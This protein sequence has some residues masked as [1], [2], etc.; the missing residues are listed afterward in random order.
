MDISKHVV[1]DKYIQLYLSIK[2]NFLTQN[3]K[4]NTPGK[5]SGDLAST[6]ESVM[7]SL[8]ELIQFTKPLRACFLINK[9]RSLTKKIC[10]NLI[11]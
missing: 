3:E 1:H 5:E 7:N 9:L 11:N 4:K 2:N 6:F 10:F 8:C